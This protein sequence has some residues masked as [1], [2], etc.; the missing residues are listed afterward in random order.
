MKRIKWIIICIA[1]FVYFKDTT[2]ITIDS[3]Y[4]DVKESRGNGEEKRIA[5]FYSTYGRDV[6]IVNFEEVKYIKK[7]EKK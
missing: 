2:S 1:F 3:K 6:A 5:H 4:A 7:I